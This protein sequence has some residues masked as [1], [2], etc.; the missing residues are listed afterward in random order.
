MTRSPS[1]GREAAPIVARDFRPCHRPIVVIIRPCF[2]EAAFASPRRRRTP[3]F[4][5]SCLEIESDE[6]AFF[7]AVIAVACGAIVV[8][9]GEKKLGC[10]SQG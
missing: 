5:L 7:A 10:T 4:G 2:S 9:A 6:G 3:S 8:T 1:R